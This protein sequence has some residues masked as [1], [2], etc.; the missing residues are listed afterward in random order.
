MGEELA[1]DE[2]LQDVVANNPKSSSELYFGEEF[3]KK[4]D[5]KFDV[6]RKLWEQLRNNKELNAYIER[7]M[8]KYVVDKVLALREE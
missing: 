4:V 2:K 8:F 1:E 5:D 7:R 6:D 3:D